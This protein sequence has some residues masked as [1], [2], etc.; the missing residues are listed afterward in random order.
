ME[1]T[2]VHDR[3]AALTVREAAELLNVS[4]RSIR[5]L[6]AKGE[7]PSFRVFSSIRIEA[8]ELDRFVQQNGATAASASRR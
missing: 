1:S 5:R 3:Q 7:L 2:L 8:Q 6:I 4:E